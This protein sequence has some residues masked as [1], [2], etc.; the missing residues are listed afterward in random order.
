MVN[1]TLYKIK[2][3]KREMYLINIDGN[4][5]YIKIVLYSISLV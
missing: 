2:I 3:M 1:F 5:L 4:H